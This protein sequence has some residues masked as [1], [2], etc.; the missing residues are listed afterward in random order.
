M[1]VSCKHRVLPGRGLW[2]GPITRPE[3]SYRVDVS[4]CELETS[5]LKNLCPR[6]L[7]SHEKKNYIAENFYAIQNQFIMIK[8]AYSE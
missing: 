4:E 8:Q 7:S 1:F 3:D 6:G 5:T 2:D